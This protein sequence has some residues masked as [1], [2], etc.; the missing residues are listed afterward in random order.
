[1]FLCFCL[2]ISFLKVRLIHNVSLYFAL[3]YAHTC[4]FASGLVNVLLFVPAVG[5]VVESRQSATWWSVMNSPLGL[6][7]GQLIR[8]LNIMHLN[9]RNKYIL[10]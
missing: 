9:P 5:A 1:M 8:E 10:V 7:E 4:H 3:R 6:Q 2:S